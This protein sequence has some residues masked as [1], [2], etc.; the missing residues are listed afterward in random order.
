M[1]WSAGPLRIIQCFQ[2]G[3][4]AAGTAGTL[5]KTSMIS[6]KRKCGSSAY[7]SSI[8]IRPLLGSGSDREAGLRDHAFGAFLIWPAITASVIA[9][10]LVF[11]IVGLDLVAI[12]KVVDGIV[13]VMLATAAMII[14]DVIIEFVISHNLKRRHLNESQKAIAVAELA[15]LEHGTNRHTKLDDGT[16]SSRL[17]NAEAASL[18]G[19]NRDTVVSAK[20]VLR[21]GTPEQI[22]AV[23]EGKMVSGEVLD[24]IEDTGARAH[25]KAQ[26]ARLFFPFGTPAAT[27]PTL[28]SDLLSSGVRHPIENVGSFQVRGVRGSHQ[29]RANPSYDPSKL[30]NCNSVNLTR[31]K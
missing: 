31:S 24:Q 13:T 6:T 25:R 8:Y 11:A 28:T 30:L 21:D 18:V 4:S 27:A 16:S 2:C 5:P 15:T 3:N 17:S 19:V 12:W 10:L 20:T 1:I 14:T 26:D 9:I 22:T 7:I 29:P 23:K